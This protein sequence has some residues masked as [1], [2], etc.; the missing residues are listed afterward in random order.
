MVLPVS[1]QL[2]FEALAAVG[3]KMGRL[4]MRMRGR[5]DVLIEW[6]IY[7]FRVAFV[8]HGVLFPVRPQD[9]KATWISVGE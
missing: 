5:R 1:P 8:F 2:S 6:R 4:R 9:V 3:V 7:V